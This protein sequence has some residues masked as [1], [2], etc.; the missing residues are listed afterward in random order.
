M[1]VNKILFFV[2]KSTKRRIFPEA[3]DAFLTD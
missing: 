1:L 3:F 2:Q